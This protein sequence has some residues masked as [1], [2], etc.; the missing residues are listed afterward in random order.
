MPKKCSSASTPRLTKCIATYSTL[1]ERGWL[2]LLVL[3]PCRECLE[4]EE[5][6]AAHPSFALLRY[7]VTRAAMAECLHAVENIEVL[8]RAMSMDNG[9]NNPF[10]TI[11]STLCRLA[12]DPRDKIYGLKG[13]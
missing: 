10:I 4:L 6:A 8:K 5:A 13:Y 3:D 7:H 12:K 2:R 9:H 11:T 1:A